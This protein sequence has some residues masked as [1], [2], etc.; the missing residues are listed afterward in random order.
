L[1]RP[2]RTGRLAASL[3]V[4]PMRG[5]WGC[6]PDLLTRIG[7]PVLASGPS[8]LAWSSQPCISEAK[9]VPE[10]RR[11]LE[12]GSLLLLCFRT[13]LLVR[14]GALI[15]AETHELRSGNLI[16]KP[17]PI[18]REQ[19]P[20]R[21]KQGRA[22]RWACELPHSKMRPSSDKDT[23]SNTA[24][25]TNNETAP[26]LRPSA[27][28]GDYGDGRQSRKNGHENHDDIADH[29]ARHVLRQFFW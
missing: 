21:E 29:S 12:C 26:L 27:K 1:I 16:Q 8:T 14:P 22:R 3:R 7:F 19:A 15:L 10:S 20:G 9:P 11:I 4:S 28:Y 18:C 23:A 5:Q 2:L 17:S 13:C 25:A 24:G 6:W